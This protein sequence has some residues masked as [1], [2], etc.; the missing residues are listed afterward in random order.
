MQPELVTEFR[1]A[2]VSPDEARRQCE[3]IPVHGSFFAAVVAAVLG[4]FQ[5]RNPDIGVR[6]T[7]QSEQTVEITVNGVNSPQENLPALAYS[8]PAPD[9]RLTGHS[10]RTSPGDKMQIT[11][12][13]R[14][15][16]TRSPSPRR[17]SHRRRSSSSSPEAPPSRS[18][19]PKRKSWW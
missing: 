13:Y 18:P 5:P 9:V 2:A 8:P 1:P 4:E 14:I 12:Q 15:R 6:V 16:R 3:G 10:T 11:L 19:S 17:R 7:H